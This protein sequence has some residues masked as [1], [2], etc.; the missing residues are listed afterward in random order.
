MKTIQDTA[1]C[2]LY[3]NKS[4]WVPVR[5]KVSILRDSRKMTSFNFDSSSPRLRA[6]RKSFRYWRVNSNWYFIS[7][8]LNNPQSSHI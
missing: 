7:L 3:Q 6:K 1:K 5:T 4:E 2:Y 8:S